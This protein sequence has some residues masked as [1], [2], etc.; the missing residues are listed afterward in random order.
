MTDSLELSAR[1]AEIIA[2]SYY[3]IELKDQFN[4]AFK[5]IQEQAME[6]NDQVNLEFKV[7]NN[8]DRP[9]VGYIIKKFK[10]L[11]YKA[12]FVSRSTTYDVN[13]KQKYCTVIIHVIWGL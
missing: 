13:S 5:T 12:S 6:G 2:D 10:A 1:D 3:E 11:G 8:R 9:A 4:S 7:D